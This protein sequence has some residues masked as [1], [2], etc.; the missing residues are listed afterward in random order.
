MKVKK[1]IVQKTESY[2]IYNLGMSELQGMYE[3]EEIAK[4]ILENV[5][6]EGAY[7]ISGYGVMYSLKNTKVYDGL[8]GPC[9]QF[10]DLTYVWWYDIISYLVKE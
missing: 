2:K 9:I 6:K 5:V 10:E 1:K 3:D 4:S 7:F 8:R